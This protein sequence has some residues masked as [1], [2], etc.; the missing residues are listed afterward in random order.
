MSNIGFGCL[1]SVTHLP[2][3]S[4]KEVTFVLTSSWRLRD[5]HPLCNYPCVWGDGSD[6]NAYEPAFRAHRDSRRQRWTP[7]ILQEKALHANSKM[8]QGEKKDEMPA[9]LL[10]RRQVVSNTG[11]NR[12]PRHKMTKIP[13]NSCQWWSTSQ[14]QGIELSYFS[15]LVLH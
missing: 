1:S 9:S 13:D 15:S 12:D 11:H 6:T 3:L 5:S 2:V 4:S 14:N 10:T 8:K 7:S